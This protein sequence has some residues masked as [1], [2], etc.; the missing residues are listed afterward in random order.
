MAFAV[1][2]IVV[3]HLVDHLHQD[4]ILS[5]N[6]GV[7]FL[8]GVGAAAGPAIAGAL[9]GWIGAIAL[10]LHLGL[11]F[12]PLALFA[13]VLSRR[14]ADEIV[15]EPAQFTPMMRTSPTVLEM[16]SPDEPA[17]QDEDADAA[18]DADPE[19]F[20]EPDAGANPEAGTDPGQIDAPATTPAPPADP[21]ALLRPPPS[22][23]PTTGT[24]ESR[25]AG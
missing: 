6:T 10:P 1:Y 20:T 13:L 4:E 16:V 12:L 5:G 9:M 7:L 11:A 14:S 25:P 23:A 15:D 17:V 19:A 24:A 21:G 3:A 22:S 2:P 8:H 18:E